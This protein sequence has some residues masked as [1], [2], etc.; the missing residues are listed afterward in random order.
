VR[1]SFRKS[2][3][4]AAGS[5]IPTWKLSED[6]HSPQPLATI[7]KIKSEEFMQ[8]GQFRPQKEFLTVVLHIQKTAGTTLRQNFEL[9]FEDR[10]LPLY[11]YW[12]ARQSVYREEAPFKS[13]DAAGKSLALREY[14]QQYVNSRQ[15]CLFGHAACFGMET[16]FNTISGLELEA[17]FITFLRDPIERCISHYYWAKGLPRHLHAQIAQES[18]WPLEEYIEKA[19][20]RTQYLCNGQLR[21]LLRSTID[22]YEP[23][24][25]L[26]LDDLQEGKKRLDQMWFVGLSETFHDDSH[27]LYGALGFNRLHPELF[28]NATKI[29]KEAAPSARRRLMEM[30]ALDMELWQYARALR[31]NF[32]RRHARSYMWNRQK[33]LWKRGRVH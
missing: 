13:A 17:R 18:A 16:L 33:A 25:E 7:A 11:W 19:S 21:Y 23:P 1:N 20:I 32:R 2:S 30:N 14:L 12:P 28:A 27:Y 6:C 22:G 4:N 15:R 10:L 31:E 9:N 26:G 8:M 3:R 24:P 29:P 5:S